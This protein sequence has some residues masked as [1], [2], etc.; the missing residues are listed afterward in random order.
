MV[1]SLFID[2]E[3]AR[4]LELVKDNIN[5]KTANTLY[6][7]SVYIGGA[8]YLGLLNQCQTPMGSRMLLTTVLQPSNS[9]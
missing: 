5:R 9:M 6:G 2:V 1:G 7:E 3:T 8:D 4:N